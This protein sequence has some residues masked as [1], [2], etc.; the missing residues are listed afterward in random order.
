MADGRKT[1]LEVRVSSTERVLVE[2][3]NPESRIQNGHHRQKGTIGADS[4]HRIPGERHGR[5]AR[6]TECPF[7][8]WEM[9]SF[10]MPYK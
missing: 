5:W 9:R 4:C 1:T 3:E 7:I 2:I 8:A 6:E 10:A